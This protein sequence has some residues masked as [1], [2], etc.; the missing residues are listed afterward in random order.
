MPR[1]CECG[2]EDRMLAWNA[3]DI[4]TNADIIGVLQFYRQEGG[5]GVVLFSTCPLCNRESVAPA[6]Y[7]LLKA[8][9]VERWIEQRRNHG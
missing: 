1:C 8:A 4:A 3:S 9:E 2:S 5:A 6:G 7:V